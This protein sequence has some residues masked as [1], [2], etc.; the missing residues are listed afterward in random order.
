[1][2]EPQSAV[3][4]G[5]IC[6]DILPDFG[7]TADQ[8]LPSLLKPGALVQTGALQ[9]SGGGPVANAGLALHRLGVPVTL[10]AKTGADPL[11]D[12]LRQ[13]VGRRSDGLAVSLAADPQSI[14]AYSIILSNKATDRIFLHCTGANDSFGPGDIDFS[15]VQRAGLFH[16]G[17][18]PVLR[19]MYRDGGRDFVEVMRSA[20]EAGATT[21]LDMCL[22]DPN[23]ES[24]RTDWRPIYK[25]VL[26]HVDVFLPSFD[27]LLYTLRRETFREL[28]AKGELQIRATPDLVQALGSELL[29]MGVKVV[30]IKMGDRGVYLRTASRDVLPPMGR[31]GPQSA[32]AWAGRERWIPCF[33]VDVVG[34]TGAGDAT[35]AGFLAGLLRGCPVERALTM[36]VAVGACNV[37][38]ADS[39]SGLRGWEETRA[40]VDAGWRRLPL[41][42]DAP[43]WAWEEESGMWIGP[44]DGL[45]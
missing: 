27:E 22:P 11:A 41:A 19:R 7:R 25:A 15:L 29:D 12:I 39:L 38:A 9:F 16:F 37:E 33:R 30:M 3:V 21:S 18:P 32:D 6:L 14:T 20:K 13:T 26:P 35:I 4:A 23:A 5:H 43:G 10:V 40:R 2:T 17:Y 31:A 44:Q 42:L 24:G 36:A 1:M 8:P 45:R 28:S 34:T